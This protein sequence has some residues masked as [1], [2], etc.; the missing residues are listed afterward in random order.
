MRARLVGPA[1]F[2]LVAAVYVNTIGHYLVW[3]DFFEI[4]QHR[5]LAADAAT[6]H[7][8]WLPDQLYGENYY[9][10]VQAL[11]NTVDWLIWGDRWAGFHLTS[12]LLH[13][14]VAVLLFF[15]GRRILARIPVTA[16]TEVAA[17][18]ALVWAVSP[19]KSESVA[20]LADRCSVLQVLTLLAFLAGLRLLERLADD[21]TFRPGPFAPAMMA[22]AYLLG[23]LSKETALT[24]PVLLLLT[25]WLCQLK[26]TWRRALVVYAPLVAV[27]V[28][29]LGVR[30]VWLWH[31]HQFEAQSNLPTRLMTQMIVTVD[32][33]RNVVA[34]F[35]PRASDV[36]ALH[37]GPD[38]AVLAAFAVWVALLGG[39]LWL[40]RRRGQRLPLWALGW[41]VV[42][43]GPT[44]NL[45]ASQRHFRGDRYLYLASFGIV[46][47][48]C[49]L[50]SRL[51]QPWPVLMCAVFLAAAGW[52][53]LT[54]N[55]EWRSNEADDTAFFALEAER[56]PH[57]REALG[58]LCLSYSQRGEYERALG[59]CRQGLQID[60]RSWSSTAWQPRS[61]SALTVDIYTQQG[62]CEQG[63]AAA[64]EAIQKYPADASFR[65][66]LGAL[67][68]RCGR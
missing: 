26:V 24:M 50:L 44:A 13:A 45:L 48:A 65:Q 64:R 1:I 11:S 36:V 68:R 27:F 40:W 28:A 29:Y 59:Y 25:Q 22:L 21:P 54:R 31:P 8:L 62:N 6:R 10:P 58:H 52:A 43:L 38:L 63:L 47:A 51:R 66:R 56:D 57:F 20:W 49:A 18:A 55:H 30:L 67:L 16:A 3:T 4:G 9:R 15:I 33:L 7:A 14:L 61:F 39:A 42:C 34:P 35:H 32:Y 53:T 19:L 17:A 60:E 46:L 23:I 41:F 12:V 5:M 37:S 2:V